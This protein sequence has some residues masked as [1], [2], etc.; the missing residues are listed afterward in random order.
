MEAELAKH[1]SKSEATGEHAP[2][3]GSSKGAGIGGA[4]VGGAAVGAAVGAGA[5]I[6]ATSGST[7]QSAVPEP[8]VDSI[9]SSKRGPEAA[10]NPSAV[11]EKSAMEQE[12]LAGTPKTNATGAPAPATSAA[13]SPTAPRATGSATPTIADENTL[14]A[15]NYTNR[16][17]CR[18]LPQRNA[19]SDQ[20]CC[21][22][23]WRCKSRCWRRVRNQ[24]DHS[25]SHRDCACWIS[26]AYVSSLL[27]KGTNTSEYSNLT[28]HTPGTAAYA[29]STPATSGLNQPTSAPAVT[30][31][32]KAATTAASQSNAV[33]LRLRQPR[34]RPRP[35]PLRRQASQCQRH[36]HPPSRSAQTSTST[37]PTVV[38]RR[39]KGHLKARPRLKGHR[40]NRRH[41]VQGPD[42]SPRP[43]T[44]HVHRPGPPKDTT[45]P[46]P[47]K[48]KTISRDISP[49]TKGAPT[50]TADRRR[51]PERDDRHGRG[52][53]VHDDRALDAVKGR[54]AGRGR[55]HEHREP[56][57]ASMA[58]SAATGSKT[59]TPTK[60]R[61]RRRRSRSGRASLA[62]SRRSSSLSLSLVEWRVR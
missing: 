56:R 23:H 9:N 60:M 32:T 24:Q 42:R 31:A 45:V 12:L 62:R 37:G 26:S 8:V 20:G 51:R 15:I 58:S 30:P 27:G 36:P 33:E 50:S 35:R 19:Q 14:P 18:R 40:S 39:G 34:P 41:A 49:F 2:G 11:A 55:A 43:D 5:G 16:S 1:V 22:R 29:S 17:P 10:A 47:T 52:R 48:S 28:H 21:G 25:S 54:R 61:R 13:L 38:Q 53:N 44:E 57:G 4:A 3:Y 6:G 46:A 7:S 59:G